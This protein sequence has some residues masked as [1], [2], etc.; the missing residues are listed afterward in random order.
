MED[1]VA[2]P[3]GQAQRLATAL[4]ELEELEECPR[5]RAA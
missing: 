5:N 3:G 4:E 2:V 1:R